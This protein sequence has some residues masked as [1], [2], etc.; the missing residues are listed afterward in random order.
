MQLD[1]K[2]CSTNNL[3]RIANWHIILQLSFSLSITA[4]VYIKPDLELETHTL[5]ISLCSIIIKTHITQ[6]AHR[7]NHTETFENVTLSNRAH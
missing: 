5:Q 7:F 2:N 4:T 6:P 3:H 1:D